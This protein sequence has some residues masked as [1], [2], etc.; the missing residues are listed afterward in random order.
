MTGFARVAFAV[1]FKDLRVEVRSREMLP[2][3]AQFA[4]LA[5]LIANFGFD[6]AGDTGR[7]APGVLWLAVV[8]VGLIA[9]GRAF[10]GE[11]DQGSLEALLLTPASRAA[12]F[13]GKALAAAL[14]LA[15]CEAV[16]VPAMGLFF[17]TP[18][19][20]GTLIATLLLSTVGMAALGCLFGAM[21]AQTRARDLLLPVLALPLWLPL[22]VYGG[23][24]IQVAMGAAGG[25]SDALER[26]LALDIL[27]VVVAALAARF[28]LND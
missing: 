22:I 4:V 17:G 21:A 26:L 12:I 27:F 10:A 9:F 11:R 16:L 19:L 15:A 7:I 23:R 8:F 6:L 20:D 2:A 1:A 18:V 13:T 14:I 25:Y 24:A 3:L 28:V 5:L